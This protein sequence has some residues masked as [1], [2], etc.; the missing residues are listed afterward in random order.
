MTA[1]E[2]NGYL[3]L[4]IEADLTRLRKCQVELAASNATIIPVHLSLKPL[5]IVEQ[6]APF[7]RPMFSVAPPWP[8]DF[9]VVD[10]DDC[11]CLIAEEILQLVRPK[12]M[13]LELAFQFPPPF[14][15]AMHW[16]I[17][18]SRHWHQD[19]R[20]DR[21]NPVSGCSLSYA[22]QKFKAFGYHLLRLTPADGVFV[23]ESVAPIIESGIG[24][25]LPQDEL[26]VFDFFEDCLFLTIS[27]F[28]REYGIL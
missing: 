5:L 4:A 15:F 27:R 13:M 28:S 20:I 14:R 12:V 2:G 6:L 18:R 9:L 11:D 22:V 8:L 17:E 3:G 1:P 26:P 25:K 7:L 21:F 23:H 24:I 16:D 19:Y 10:I